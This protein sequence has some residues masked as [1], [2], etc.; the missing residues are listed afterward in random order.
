MFRLL[1]AIGFALL[2][3]LQSLFVQTVHIQQGADHVFRYGAVAWFF[4]VLFAVLPLLFAVLAWKW[5]RDAGGA[6]I[7][8]IAA[9]VM[10]FVVAPQIIFERVEL[11]ET[12]WK[13]RREWSHQQYNADIAWS[14]IREVTKVMKEDLSF[15]QKWYIG[16]D[17]TL[18][19]GRQIKFPSN[20]VLTAAS[21]V[22]DEELQKRELPMNLR[23]TMVPKAQ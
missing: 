12:E 20:T 19:D 7:L 22:I 8:L 1:I 3:F 14:D 10:F 21:P 18:K 9:P 4:V 16:Y 23:K 5:L 6:I 15:G 13:H 2:L 11:T 17:I